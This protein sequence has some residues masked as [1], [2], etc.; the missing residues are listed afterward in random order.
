VITGHFFSGAVEQDAQALQFIEL[1]LQE[2]THDRHNDRQANVPQHHFHAS[3]FSFVSPVSG[4]H[5]S[6]GNVLCVTGF[7]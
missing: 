6:L 1:A 2:K 7:E 5:F 4:A 3:P